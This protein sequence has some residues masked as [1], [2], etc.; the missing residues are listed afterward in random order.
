MEGFDVL[1]LGGG[2]AGCVLAA[3]LSEDPDRSV[4][5]VEA[6]P[7][8]G[9]YIDGRWPADVLDARQLALDSHCWRR[10]DEDDRSQLRAR[11]L[12]GCSAHNACVLVSGD[13]PGLRDQRRG[14]RDEAPLARVGAA[15]GARSGGAA[16]DRPRLPARRRRRRRSRRGLRGAARARPHRASQPLRG[17]RAEAGR[18]GRRGLARPRERAR[19]LPPDRYVPDRPRG[20]R[21]APSAGIREP[22]RRG[23]VGD[24]DDPTGEHASLDRRD[25]GACGRVDPAR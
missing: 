23:C 7:D 4:C 5:L 13:R 1:V 11:I 19:L 9:P 15:D 12:G 18:R 6:G 3:R 21:A 24:A 14:L 10:D 17:P 2:P 8:Y 25:R 16:C 22:L 20:R